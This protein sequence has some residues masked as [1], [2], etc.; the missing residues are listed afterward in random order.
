MNFLPL[1]IAMSGSM[2]HPDGRANLTGRSVVLARSAFDDVQLRNALDD[3][4]YMYEELSKED[5]GD[6]ALS[7]KRHEDTPLLP[8]SGGP[9]QQ[10]SFPELPGHFDLSGNLKYFVPQSPEKVKPRFLLYSNKATSQDKLLF[11]T[12]LDPA[13]FAQLA[14]LLQPGSKLYF[15]VHGFLSSAKTPWMLDMKDEILDQEADVSVVLVD[16]SKG[17]SSILGYS[18]AAANT[19]TVARSLAFLVKTLS[20]AGVISPKDVHYIGHSL[21][22]QTGGFFGR[23]VRELTGQLVSRIT[24]LDPAGPLFES[25]GV[26]LRAEHAEFVDVLHTSVGRSWTDVVQGRLGML[27]SCGHVD[28]YPNGGKQQPGCWRFS[29][30]SHS[31]ATKYYADSIRSCEFPTRSCDSYEAFKSGACEP[32]CQ[33]GERC[34]RMGHPA[35]MPLQ[36]NHFTET[37]KTRCLEAVHSRRMETPTPQ[38]GAEP[39]SINVDD[40]LLSSLGRSVTIMLEDA[41]PEERQE[42]LDALKEQRSPLGTLNLRD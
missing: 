30:C 22:A 15:I 5:F 34:G 20:D 14:S 28:F 13:G 29:S 38:R 42:L 8:Y 35:S 41:T 10:L 7:V 2:R 31:K 37:T 36:G 19:R 6:I 11:E 12:G 27:A 4:S 21:G 32:R 23:D 26:H 24:G 33:D 16:W 17:C 1:L 39:R 3:T 9:A 18:T 40:M 25:R